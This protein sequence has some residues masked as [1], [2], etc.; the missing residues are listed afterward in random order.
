MYHAE[1]DPSDLGGI[2]VD[3]SHR[4]F[5]E[6]IPE[7]KFLANFKFHR[8]VV[9]GLVEVQK[10]FVRVVHMPPDAYP[11]TI[12]APKDID[13]GLDL[14]EA[15]SL[16]LIQPK[17]GAAPASGACHDTTLPR[18]LEGDLSGLGLITK[19]DDVGVLFEKGDILSE[20]RGGCGSSGKN[21][22]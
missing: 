20:T 17:P 5:A 9:S 4:A 10:V 3:E 13:M 12:S 15:M 19:N 2:I 7:A 11:E 16:R 1:M 18:W 6:P 14:R 21:D 22:G 8:F